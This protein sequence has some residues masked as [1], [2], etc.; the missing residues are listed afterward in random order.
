M[1]VIFGLICALGLIAVVGHGIW[2][3]VVAVVR[4]ITGESAPS[5]T[6]SRKTN[7]C[8]WCDAPLLA[9]AHGCSSC[10]WPRTSD[11][12]RRAEAGILALKHKLKH[13][14]Q[15]G[16]LD[17]SVTQRL[18]EQLGAELATIE[19]AR[20]TIQPPQVEP[21]VELPTLPPITAIETFDAEV[22]DEPVA[23][24]EPA[25]TYGIAQEQP[26]STAE[27]NDIVAARM[28][29]YVRRE[30]DRLPPP[31]PP[32]P[33]QPRKPFA[34]VLV[35]FLEEKNIRWGELIG[36]LLIVGSSIALV[37]SFWNAIAARPLLKFG[38]FNGITAGL[39]G[40]G[41]YI[42]RHWKL[43]NTSQGLLIIATLLVPLNFLAITAF[44][45]GSTGVDTLTVIGEVASIGVFVALVW[46]TGSVI[47]PGLQWP[48]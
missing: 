42:H 17:E 29:T 34:E 1:E 8:P 26:G 16:L 27:V 3:A 5:S 11:P 13:L 20:A 6:S 10:G 12:A 48:L 18:H 40:L 44:S 41:H 15:V 39:F 35:S 31:P 14:Q 32:K 24:R 28:E 37:L 4:L 43:A 46:L 21:P 7:D 33:Y 30:E 47:T 23:L 25:A 9:G 22:I 38:L 36:G 2:I 19:S 45:Q